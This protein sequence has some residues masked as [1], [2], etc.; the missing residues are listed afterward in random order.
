VRIS[1][2]QSVLHWAQDLPHHVGAYL[3][4]LSLPKQPGRYRPVTL[5]STHLGSELSLGFSCFALKLYLTLGLWNRLPAEHRH[6]WINFI[7][8][9]QTHQELQGCSLGLN[10]FFDPA[11]YEYLRTT[12]CTSGAHSPSLGQVLRRRASSRQ[13]LL[14]LFRRAPSSA[15]M[16]V[17]ERLRRYVHAETKQAISTLADIGEEPL[18][19]YCEFETEPHKVTAYLNG[20][21]WSAPWGA[22]AHFAALCTF[23]ATQGPRFLS[24]SETADLQAVLRKFIKGKLDTDTGAYF[25]GAR[26]EH[27]QLINGAMN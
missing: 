13:W 14:S 21:D 19:P 3:E 15:S 4:R 5:G 9:F 11:A 24:S 18:K 1:N 27:G 25:T 22:G 17:A 12:H 10:S 26:V 2:P 20:F 8:R 6:E 7:K 16:P 23:A